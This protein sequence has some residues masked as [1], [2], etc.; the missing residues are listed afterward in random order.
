LKAGVVTPRAAG[1]MESALVVSSVISRIDG[2]DGG[3][4]AGGAGVPRS[5][6]AVASKKARPSAVK[7]LTGQ[8]VSARCCAWA[9]API[10][11]ASGL[12]ITDTGM[13]ATRWAMGS[14]SRKASMKAPDSSAGRILGAIPPP[15]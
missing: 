14:L 3:A 8:D 10:S 13:A 7:R 15:M 6:A 2:F 5:Q 11:P 9:E 12:R 1:P 4:T